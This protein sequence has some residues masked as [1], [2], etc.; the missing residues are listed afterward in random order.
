MPRQCRDR[1]ANIG[2]LLEPSVTIPQ[3]ATNITIS[4][5]GQFSWRVPGSQT[6]QQ[7]PTMQ[8]ANFIKPQG[9]LKMGE[10]LYQES[11]ASGTAQQGNAGQ[12]GMG[13]IQQ[14]SLLE[15][16]NVVIPSAR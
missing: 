9:L 10:T 1:L 6:L 4:A 11:D 7:G 15:Q 14:G 12:N 3:D 16:S 8:L 5:A 13:T 2:R